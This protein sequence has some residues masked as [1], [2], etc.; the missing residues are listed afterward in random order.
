MSSFHNAGHVFGDEILMLH[1]GNRMLHPHHRANL[2]DPVSTGVDDDFCANI[3]LVRMYCPA[4]IGMLRKVRDRGEPV[5]LS[6]DG[7]GSAR[8][9]LAELSRIDMSIGWVPEAT[10]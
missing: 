6:S 5:D 10:H 1:T 9:G 4:V 2:I 8:Q 7:A 3:T